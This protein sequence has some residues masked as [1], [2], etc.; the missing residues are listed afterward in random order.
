[1]PKTTPKPPPTRMRLLSGFGKEIKKRRKEKELSQTE[2][3]ILLQTHYTYILRLE[4]GEANPT[5]TTILSL[6]DNL[7]I[8]L[9]EFFSWLG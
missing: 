3:A 7:G 4:N 8:E 1:M 6:A 2:L 5:L 9:E